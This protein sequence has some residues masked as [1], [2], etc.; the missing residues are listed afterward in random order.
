MWAIVASGVMK[1]SSLST[2]SYLVEPSI[3]IV[4]PQ[5]QV[6]S[7]FVISSQ[8]LSKLHLTRMVQLAISRNNSV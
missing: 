5:L 2:A 4:S 6:I 3:C 8:L 1:P 7:Q